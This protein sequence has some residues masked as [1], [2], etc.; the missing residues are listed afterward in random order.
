MGIGGATQQTDSNTLSSYHNPAGLGYITQTTIA[1]AFRNLPQSNTA[2]SGRFSDPTF[3]TDKEV[4]QRRITHLGVAFPIK[5]GAVGLSYTMG[6]YIKDI[7]VGNGLSDGALRINNLLETLQAQTDFFTVS[8]GKQSTGLNYGVGLVIANQ[9]LSDV[10]SYDTFDNANNFIGTTRFSNSGNTTGIGAVVGVQMSPG[11]NGKS[12]V[13]LSVR[14]PIKLSNNS[15]TSPYLNKLPG[16]V[17]LG[18]ASRTDGLRGGRDFM[19]AGGQIDYFFGSDKGGALKRKDVMT[20]GLGF[21]YNMHRFNARIPVRIGY[22]F[23]PS[24][25]DGFDDRNTFTF[26]LGY[27]PEN[28]KLG[29]DVNFGLPT[30]GGGYDLGLSVSYKVGK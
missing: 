9:Y 16:R 17:S 6:G 3:S 22:A 8:W 15:Q 26:G 23:I 18:M 5:N 24:G 10:G 2:L 14:T 21:E 7:K 29:V 28:G 12:V 1:A 20:A 4:G 19:V 30:G 27:R 25:G 11:G 13:G